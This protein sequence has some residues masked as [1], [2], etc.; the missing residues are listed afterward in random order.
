M[1]QATCTKW[2]SGTFRGRRFTVPYFLVRSSGPSKHL[3]VQVAI[4]VSYV[5]M[6]RTVPVPVPEVDLTLIQDGLS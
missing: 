6:G 2:D 3:S 4:L 1:D 5:P